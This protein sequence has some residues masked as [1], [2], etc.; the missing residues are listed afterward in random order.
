[1]TPFEE[2]MENMKQVGMLL[3]RA[4][5]DWN[6]GYY[7]KGEYVYVGLYTAVSWESALLIHELLH[8]KKNITC[9]VTD[10]MLHVECPISHEERAQVRKMEDY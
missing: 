1:M 9:L 5:H 4:V 6:Y 8:G 2:V 7:D 3:E 10:K